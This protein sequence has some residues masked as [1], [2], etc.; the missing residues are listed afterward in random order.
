MYL[1]SI[2]PRVSGKF[3]QVLRSSNVSMD[4]LKELNMACTMRTVGKLRRFLHYHAQTS[5]FDITMHG[6]L[7]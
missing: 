3:E 5:F 4:G 1:R 6:T 7:R 2:I